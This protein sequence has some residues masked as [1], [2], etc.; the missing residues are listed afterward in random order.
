MLPD[1]Y[2]RK[3][4]QDLSEVEAQVEAEMRREPDSEPLDESQSDELPP[5]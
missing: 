4:K 5:P 1:D 3:L 2:M